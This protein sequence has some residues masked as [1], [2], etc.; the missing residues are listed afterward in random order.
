MK[1]AALFLSWLLLFGQARA[2]DY[3]AGPGTSNAQLTV[4][5][6]QTAHDEIV[7]T[8][9]FVNDGVHSTSLSDFFSTAGGFTAPL[10]GKSIVINGCGSAGIDLVTTISAVPSTTHLTLAAPCT[11]PVPW[12]TVGRALNAATTGVT[13]SYLVNDVLTVTGG[14]KTTAGQFTIVSLGVN[15]PAVNAGG[16]GGANGA[17]T[18]QGTSGV[19]RTNFLGGAN[20]AAGYF[21]ATG[22]VSGGVLQ[23]GLVVVQEGDYSTAP[24][25]QAAEPVLPISGCAGLTGATVALKMTGHALQQTLAGNYTVMPANPVSVTG[26]AGTGQTLNL[27]AD[28]VGGYWAIGT[29]DTAAINA[30]ITT[31]TVTNPGGTVVLPVGRHLVLGA[32][33]I[34]FNATSP[35]PTQNF[36]RLTG[37]GQLAGVGEVNQTKYTNS[38]PVSLWGLSGTTLDMRYSGSGSQSAKIQSIGAG[39]FE[40]DHFLLWDGGTDNFLM[41]LT[42]NTLM[43]VHDMTVSGNPTC[44]QM[45]CQQNFLR[46][47]GITAASSVL[48]GVLAT[49]GFQ[50]YGSYIHYN[51]FDHL[52]EVVQYGGSANGVVQENNTYAYTNGSYSPGSGAITLYGAGLGTTSDHF[53]AETIECTGYVNCVVL[54]ATSGGSNQQNYLEHIECYDTN[55]GNPS[56]SC[57]NMGSTSLYNTVVAPFQ[58]SDIASLYF[59]TTDI[60]KQNY[61]GGGVPGTYSQSYLMQK[62]STPALGLGGVTAPGTDLET[63][64]GTGT[65]WLKCNAGNGA[66]LGCAYIM[67]LNSSLKA[68]VG[69]HQSFSG[70]SNTNLLIEDNTGIDENIGNNTIAT[71]SA[72]L[73]TFGQAASVPI[74]IAS[75]QATAPIVTGTGSPTI[76]G[77]D[78][79]GTVTAG[80]LAT[81]VIITFNVAYTS[82]P[83]CMVSWRGSPLV[84]QSYTVSAAAITITQTATSGDLIDYVCIAPSGG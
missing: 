31:A 24:T 29:D 3:V 18:V 40:V 60:T 74:H 80:A 54:K 83:H 13:V 62:I 32:L 1:I 50:G 19:T 51:F 30:A 64:I 37:G 36:L 56:L 49:N 75:A 71:Q 58:E 22:T 11:L 67:Y 12:S 84:T 2:A 63:G 59:V 7:G 6:A 78:T 79:A 26:G 8:D 76:A 72:T 27:T 34:P 21:T 45:T 69:T 73:K 28:P 53:R 82:P 55:V 17:C 70:G 42:T 81:S 46:L 66:G 65:H 39:S 52:Q 14:T 77:T 44:F 9:G 16:S 4:V 20:P 38:M 41:M 47:G 43:H 25:S 10:K 68:F 33:V 48:G 23:A 15:A 57:I 5:P 35:A 61:I